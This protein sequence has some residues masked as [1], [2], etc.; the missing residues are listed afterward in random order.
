MPNETVVSCYFNKEN[1]VNSNKAVDQGDKGCTVPVEIDD[2]I[3]GPETPGMR[4]LVPRLKRV[5]EDSTKFEGKNDCSVV[6]PFKRVKLLQDMKVKSEKIEGET[7]MTSKFEWLDPSRIRDA[8][9]R[10]PSDPLYNK[11][12]LYIPPDAMKKMSA[13]RKQYWSVKS[14]YMDL[15]LFFKVVS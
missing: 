10:R 5:Q 6:D 7:E 15:V 14:Q 8:N 3:F 11:R 4:P 9:G 2:D 1:A 12:T 13:S